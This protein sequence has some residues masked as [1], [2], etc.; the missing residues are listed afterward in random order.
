[1][2]CVIDATGKTLIAHPHYIRDN[3]IVRGKNNAGC[4]NRS[5][6][7]VLSRLKGQLYMKVT[8]CILMANMRSAGH[9]QFPINDF[10]ALPAPI[11]GHDL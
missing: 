2:S 3:S 8:A 9:K 11:I 7:L 6:E 4:L 5:A 10:V 1:M